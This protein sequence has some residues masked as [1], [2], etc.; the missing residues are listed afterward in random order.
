MTTSSPILGDSCPT[1]CDCRQKRYD[2]APTLTK[3]AKNAFRAASESVGDTSESVSGASESASGASESVSDA[4]ERLR[5]VS[6]A[7]GGASGCLSFRAGCDHSSVGSVGSGSPGCP[8][9]LRCAS[10]SGIRW[11]RR[12]TTVR[13]FDT[14]IDDGDD[15]FSPPTLSL[16]ALQLTKQASPPL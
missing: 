16:V 10:P 3:R 12:F 9:A 14:P 8:G 4:S 6:E 1:L 5:G 7:A 2:R 13:A 11:S 15:P